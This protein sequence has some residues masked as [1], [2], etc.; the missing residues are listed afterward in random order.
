M[1][2][3]IPAF[4][5]YTVDDIGRVFSF[6]SGQKTELVGSVSKYRGV[7]LRR[8]GKTFRR[9]VHRLV[10]NAFLNLPDSEGEINHI[11]GDK[12]NNRLDNIEI[13]TRSEN[14]K[15]AVRTGL[16]TAPT[17]AHKE[18]MRRR[19]G[20]A[21]SLFTLDEASDILEMKDVLGL[22]CREVAKI[23]GCSKD[24][25]QRLANGSMRY[26]KDGSI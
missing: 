7:L 21:K 11:D 14:M 26:F 25:I 6:K 2:K 9:N 5:E 24:P 4:P 23:V 1:E 10:A 22:T 12:Q 19:C 8:D 13:T 20:E 3:T 17:E 18:L 15:H 16:W